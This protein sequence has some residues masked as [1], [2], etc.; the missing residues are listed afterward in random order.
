MHQAKILHSDPKPRNMMIAENRVLWIDFDS[1]QTFL[2]DQA[3][4]SIPSQM[5]QGRGRT[6]GV[7][8]GSFD[9]RFGRREDKPHIL[10]LLRSVCLEKLETIYHNHNGMWAG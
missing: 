5:V 1:A 2:E 7:L 3:L 4:T 10:L 8:R 9:P 6:D